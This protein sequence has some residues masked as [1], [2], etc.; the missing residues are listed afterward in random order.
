MP[1]IASWDL[2]RR[3]K[4]KMREAFSIM[5]KAR[6]RKEQFMENISGR[7]SIKLMN[8]QTSYQRLLKN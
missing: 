3:L 8:K 2:E 6:F 7:H 1:R 5:D 4:L